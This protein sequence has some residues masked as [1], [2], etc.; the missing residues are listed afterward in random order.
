MKLLTALAL[1]TSLTATAQLDSA[2]I[3]LLDHYPVGG[4]VALA[5]LDGDST[6]Y[7][8]ARKTAEG[9]VEV[10]NRNSAF[11]IGSVTKVM[12]ATL[13]A[14]AVTE[15][16]IELEDEVNAVYD[17][18]FADSAGFTYAQLASHS[19]G[20]PRLPSNMPGLILSPGDPYG[21]YTP[22]LL[23]TYLKDEMTLTDAGKSAYSNL[24]FGILAYTLTHRL[25]DS[26]LKTALRTTIFDPLGMDRTSEGP[27][28]S[29][30]VTVPGYNIDGTPAPY[31]Y[32]TDAM[33]GAGSVVS[34]AADLAKFLRA[35]FDE[36]NEVLALTRKPIV[37]VNDRMSVGLGWQIIQPEPGRTIYWHNGGVAGYRSFVGVDTENERAVVVL[38]NALLMGQEVD[39]AGMS[40]L[41]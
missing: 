22:E 32:F 37:Q 7:Y 11:A 31:W 5:Y 24:G 15:G 20:L 21:S 26:N 29:R 39:G 25:E 41:R 35:H 9:I 8:G 16:E 1:M 34:T 33:A 12:T 4:E 13:L 28:S 36:S 30:A 10:D 27:D 6:R 14:R 38:T 23:E 17:F 19:A 18:P 2:A 3:K 40:L